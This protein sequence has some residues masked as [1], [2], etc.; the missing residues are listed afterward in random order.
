M[1]MNDAVPSSKK[2]LVTVDIGS[3][4]CTAQN[5]QSAMIKTF[6]RQDIKQPSAPAKAHINGYRCRSAAS[7]DR[8]SSLD[9]VSAW[10][11]LSV[12]GSSMS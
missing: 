10:T 12:A 1:I 7:T 11:L 9:L 4:I 5:L 8:L 3:A 6:T 2:V